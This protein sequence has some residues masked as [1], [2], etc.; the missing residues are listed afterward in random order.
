MS[1]IARTVSV[2]TLTRHL[3]RASLR[4]PVLPVP[5]GGVANLAR[6]DGAY[7]LVR[8]VPGGGFSHW[9]ADRGNSGVFDAVAVPVTTSAAHSHPSLAFTHRGR[10]I[11]SLYDDGTAGAAAGTYEAY[12]DGDGDFGT[13]GAAALMVSG[14]KYPKVRGGRGGDILRVYYLGSAA[15][16]T[17]WCTR[18][19]PDGVQSSPVQ[20]T[21]GTVALSAGEGPPDLDH[22]A[23]GDSPWRLVLLESGATAPAEFVNYDDGA[24]P[25]WK[26]VG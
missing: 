1:V 4:V 25:A 12:S 26:R 20:L 21:D 14:A 15:P 18:Q 10:L 8:P 19:G 7:H 2:H 17:V 22:I 13:W 6:T 23:A 5:A 11:L 9:R 16:Y 24:G 3:T